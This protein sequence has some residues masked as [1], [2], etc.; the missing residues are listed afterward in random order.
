[1]IHQRTQVL[2]KTRRT[3]MF[4]DCLRLI[5]DRGLQ[6]RRGLGDEVVQPL[7]AWT[8]QL[9][10]TLETNGILQDRSFAGS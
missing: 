7:D 5:L 2:R 6:Q 9:E 8:Q 4:G 10:Q 3:Q 1:M